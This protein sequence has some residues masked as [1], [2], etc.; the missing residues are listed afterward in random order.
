MKREVA[1]NDVPIAVEEIII[2][3]VNRSLRIH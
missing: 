1:E 2:M 3:D